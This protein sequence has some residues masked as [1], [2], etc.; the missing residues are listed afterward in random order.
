M[1]TNGSPAL[2]CRDKWLLQ[3]SFIYSSMMS[4]SSEEI[5]VATSGTDLD[6]PGCFVFLPVH[7]EKGV[8]LIVSE[9]GDLEPCPKKTRAW[10]PSLWK[11]ST[12]LNRVSTI[13][14]SYI[15]SCL[16]SSV[17]PAGSIAAVHVYIIHCGCV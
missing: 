2:T 4:N 3:V 13:F 1:K 14:P 12:L 9:W 8:S 5:E 10:S 11:E 7:G 17:C 16:F 6:G 15:F